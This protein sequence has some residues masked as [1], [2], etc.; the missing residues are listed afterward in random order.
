MPDRTPLG[1]RKQPRQDRAAATVAAIVEAAAQVLEEQGFENYTTNAIARRAGVSIGSLYQ[2]FPS[3]D[4]ITRVLVD[5]EN[6]A[7]LAEIGLITD[8]GTGSS[9]MRRL[10]EIA[11]GHQLRRPA[12]ARLLDEAE[13]WL[14]AGDAAPE[15]AGQLGRVFRLGLAAHP[16]N[17]EA[18]RPRAVADLLAI[19]KGMVD[20]AGARGETDAAGLIDRVMRAV[21]GY[22]AV[23]E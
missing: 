6:A 22:L 15:I 16:L 12:L 2:Y 18:T 7:L 1:P 20:A 5:R 13:R 3:K 9:A 21:I 17:T 11:V 8:S 23:P 14:P 4:A 10:V 19:I